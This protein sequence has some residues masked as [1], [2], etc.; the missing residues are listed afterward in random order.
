GFEPISWSKAFEIISTRFAAAKKPGVIGSNHTTN[1]EN[2]FL[3]KFARQGLKTNN[4]DHHRTGDLA[5]LF[6]ALS[7]KN[8]VLATV[9]DLYTAKAVL[10]IGTDLS[11]QHPF[12]AF[13]VRANVRHHNAHVY[14]VTSGPVREDKQAVAS[15]RDLGELESLRDK[16]K[17][18]PN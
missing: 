15:L 10:V 6:D 12:L 3:Q 7:G 1:E 5:T 16:L 2:Y 11:Q 9:D 4:I 18:E 13:Q 8:D 17:A 14:T